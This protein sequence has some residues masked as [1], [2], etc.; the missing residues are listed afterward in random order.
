MQLRAR[1][2]AGSGAAGSVR[3]K[4]QLPATPRHL[5]AARQQPAHPSCDAEEQCPLS[6]AA[7]KPQRRAV[8]AR[9]A[10]KSG[11]AEAWWKVDSEAWVDCHDAEQFK[12]EVHQ[13]SS[14]FVIVGE[15][16]IAPG[17]RRGP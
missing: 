14:E 4:Q 7:W 5:H 9:G 15:F 12:R 8:V 13:A 11:V 16:V 6:S 1:A 10:I 3:P 2:A 17:R